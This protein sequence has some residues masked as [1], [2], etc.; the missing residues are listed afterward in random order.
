[1]EEC[2]V[3]LYKVGKASSNSSKKRML[4]IIGSYFDTYRVTPMVRIVRDRVCEDVFTKEAECHKRLKEFA[5]ASEKAFS[6]HTEVFRCS[7]E[8][9][10]AVYEEVLYGV[11]VELSDDTVELQKS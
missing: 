5:Y 10:I 6:G 1:M 7:K 11:Q 2:E 9:V 3:P 4:E 8:D